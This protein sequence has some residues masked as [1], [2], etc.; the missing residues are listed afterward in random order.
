MHVLGLVKSL[1][2][3]M[4]SVPLHLCSPLRTLSLSQ[5]SL[6]SKALWLAASTVSWLVAVL[7]ALRWG[8]L[9]CTHM[10]LPLPKWWRWPV[11]RS[12]WRSPQSASRSSGMSGNALR[13]A[14]VS[15]KEL[16]QGAAS[17]VSPLLHMRRLL[18]A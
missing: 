1:V 10:V 3:L 4:A 8:L 13:S 5:A 11:S 12:A 2:M 14:A 15:A 18:V 6:S 9:M 17:S 7:A 16:G